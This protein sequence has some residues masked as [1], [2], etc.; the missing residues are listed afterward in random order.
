[1]TIEF[2]TSEVDRLAVDLSRAEGRLRTRA[3]QVLYVGANKIKRG[4]RDDA[5]GHNFLSGLPMPVSYDKLGQFDYEIGF[6]KE[7][8][9]NLAAIAAFGTPRSA[10]VMD[11]TA[12][13]RRETP[14]IVEK[15][16]DA[17]EDSVL[18]TDAS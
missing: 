1:M 2:D 18:G 17:A 14:I 12:A 16:G 4:M 9:G 15:L 6:D 11:H 8:Q 5:R 3:G 10:P 7:G 13:L